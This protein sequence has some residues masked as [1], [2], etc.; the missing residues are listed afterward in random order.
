VR[1]GLRNTGTRTGREV[2]QIYLAPAEPDGARPDSWLAGFAVTTAA[3][4]EAVH[5]EVVI[6]QRAV[7][8]WDTP[9][10]CWRKVPGSY[11]ILVGRSQSDIRQETL[12]EVRA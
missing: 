3:P 6:A 11:R 12:F 7:E 10:H 9:G 2:V 5:A 1:V 8:S 4:G